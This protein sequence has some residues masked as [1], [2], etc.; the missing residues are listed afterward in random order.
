MS[1]IQLPD[2]LL[3][4]QLALA[5]TRTLKSISSLMHLQVCYLYCLF[6]LILKN[7]PDSTEL[8]PG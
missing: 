2:P 3:N 4:V 8:F 6:S 5:R 7:N 1:G